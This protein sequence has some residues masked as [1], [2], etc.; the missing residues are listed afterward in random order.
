MYCRAHK[1]A[2]LTP[3][4]HTVPPATCDSPVVVPA[5]NDFTKGMV[6]NTFHR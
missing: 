3:N 1:T 2:T 6:C 4:Q 5:L